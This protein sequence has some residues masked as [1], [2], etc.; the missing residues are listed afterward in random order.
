MRSPGSAG[1]GSRAFAEHRVPGR[2]QV[3]HLQPRRVE[4]VG[5]LVEIAAGEL[6]LP[7]PDAAESGGGVNRHVG[8]EG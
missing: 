5:D 4:R 7:H 8:V 1:P 2:H 3:G 6:G